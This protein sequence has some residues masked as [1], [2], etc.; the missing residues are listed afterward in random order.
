M[1]LAKVAK[2][3]TVPDRVARLLKEI[4]RLDKARSKETYENINLRIKLAERT[5]ERDKARGALRG[6][7]DN[8]GFIHARVNC[9]HIAEAS[10]ALGEK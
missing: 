3:S 6:M 4:E 1:T 7:L 9:I 10:R 8:H 5:K 2:T